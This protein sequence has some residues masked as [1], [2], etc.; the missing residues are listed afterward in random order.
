MV[1]KTV[2]DWDAVVSVGE[3]ASAVDEVEVTPPALLL[4]LE[5]LWGGWVVLAG[6]WVGWS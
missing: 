6:F 3:A 4:L 1:V 5:V 2:V